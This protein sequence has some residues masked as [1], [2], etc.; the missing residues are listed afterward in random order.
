MLWSGDI[1]LLVKNF[2]FV[3]YIGGFDFLGDIRGGDSR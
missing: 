1:M 2:F 3:V